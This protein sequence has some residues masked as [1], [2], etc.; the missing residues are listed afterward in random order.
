MASEAGYFLVL[1]FTLEQFI[2]LIDGICGSKY[3]LV[4]KIEPLAMDLAGTYSIPTFI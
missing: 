1:L 2:R 3:R 4:I